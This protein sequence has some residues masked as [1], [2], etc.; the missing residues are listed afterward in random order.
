VLKNAEDFEAIPKRW[1]IRT[2]GPLVEHPTHQSLDERVIPYPDTVDWCQCH[3]YGRPMD[4][5][6][7][8][9][10]LAIVEVCQV[11]HNVPQRS[12]MERNGERTKEVLEGLPRALIA[13]F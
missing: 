4:T 12:L 10:K 3:R 13:V 1:S 2:R 5:N 8:P 6:G 11:V 7:A 9:R